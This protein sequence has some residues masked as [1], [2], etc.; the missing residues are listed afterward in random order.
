MKNILAILAL[1]I[2]FGTAFLAGRHFAPERVEYLPADTTQSVAKKNVPPPDPI[3]IYTKGEAVRDTFWMAVDSSAIIGEYLR[4]N[5]QIGMPLEFVE[6]QYKEDEV[7]DITIGGWKPEG[8]KENRYAPSLISSE[9]FQRTITIT[10]P[11]VRYERT[12]PKF[13]IGVQVGY[14]ISKNGASPYVGVGVQW[15]IITW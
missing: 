15:N 7:Y 11:E 6:L 8:D 9:V 12:K 4:K 10:K 14:G 1:L 3:R 2:L 13:G 5:G